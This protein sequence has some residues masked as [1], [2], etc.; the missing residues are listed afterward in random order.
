MPRK[1]PVSDRSGSDTGEYGPEVKKQRT[2]L[3]RGKLEA[4]VEDFLD[5]LS[6]VATES[7]KKFNS[8]EEKDGRRGVVALDIPLLE[9]YLKELRGMTDTKALVAKI[10]EIDTELAQGKVHFEEYV[11]DEGAKNEKVGRLVERTLRA[12]ISRIEKARGQLPG[13]C[14][15]W[16]GC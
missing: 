8:L 16:M 11:V 9:I 2:L 6:P 5:L 7:L 10:N 1:R 14:S 4:V 15:H 12:V 13:R 3:H